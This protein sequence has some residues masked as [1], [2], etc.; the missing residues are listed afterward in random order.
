M[1]DKGNPKGNSLMILVV[2]VLQVTSLHA[3][4]D[5]ENESSKGKLSTVCCIPDVTFRGSS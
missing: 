3:V 1:G 4:I 2:D 5:S